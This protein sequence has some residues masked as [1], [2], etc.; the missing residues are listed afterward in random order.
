LKA[1]EHEKTTDE[2][3]EAWIMS[4]VNK[5]PKVQIADS[6]ATPSTVTTTAP[7]LKS[8]LRRA[9]NSKN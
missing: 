2:E 4:L 9:K 1:I 7:S 6:T 5:N 3:T 8:I